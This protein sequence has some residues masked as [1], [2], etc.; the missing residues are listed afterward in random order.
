MRTLPLIGALCATVGCRVNADDFKHSMVVDKPWQPEVDPPAGD[1][2]SETRLY[3]LL[4]A[5]ELGLESHQAGQRVRMLTWLRSTQLTDAE[6]TKLATLGQKAT[7][8]A[9][10]DRAAQ[11]EMSAREAALLLPI[12]T[13]LEHALTRPD[14]TTAELEALSVELAKARATLT[15]ELDPHTQHRTRVRALLEDISA[16]MEHL[17][18]DKRNTVGQCRFVLIEHAAPLTN[19]GTYAGLVGMR[20]D[21]GDFSALQTADDIEMDGPIDLG[22]L[23]GL[24]HLRAPPSGYMVG[25]ALDGVL[26]LA[27][28]D[29]AFLPAVEAV[30]ASRGLSMPGV[31]PQEPSTMPTTESSD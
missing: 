1:T 27:M 20:W 15:A 23:W 12:Y 17:S 28:L 21:R 5:G 19:P 11:A 6:L 9:A 24:E 29:P 7:R 3:Q 8:E 4:Y 13:R 2:P 14:A 18:H 22:G 25:S 31:V 10:A 30:L 16:W 26:L